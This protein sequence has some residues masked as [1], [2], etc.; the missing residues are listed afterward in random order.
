MK[1]VAHAVMFERPTDVSMAES[2]LMQKSLE[3]ANFE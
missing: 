2:Q 3:N 1:G